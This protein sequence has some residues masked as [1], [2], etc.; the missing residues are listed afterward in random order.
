MSDANSPQKIFLH[1]AVPLG[2]YILVFGGRF[3]NFRKHISVSHHIIWMYN[4][5]TEQW[6]KYIIPEKELCPPDTAGSSAVAIT[7][8]VFLFGGYN[9]SQET[10]SNEL[11]ELS[12]SSKGS[13]TW[14]KVTTENIKVPSP[15]NDHSGWTYSGKLWIFGGFGPSLDRY[16]NDN[17]EFLH[18]LRG[19]CNNQLLSFNPSSKQWTNP[20]CSGFI[21]TP[22]DS[23]AS[24]NIGD[25]VWLYSGQNNSV[26][27]NELYEL[28]MSSLMWTHV[29]TGKTNPQTRT[30]CSLNAITHDQLLLYGGSGSYKTILN[31]TWILDLSSKTWKQYKPG[32]YRRLYHTGSKGINSNSII[33]GGVISSMDSCDDYPTT[34]CIMLEP[35]SLQQLAMQTI[36]KRRS[37]LPWECLPKK[38]I[39]LLGMSSHEENTGEI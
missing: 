3:G 19:S 13:F 36:Y 39:T 28:N 21:P 18:S 14:S 38:L 26:V 7:E 25:K 8:D 31:D 23:H 33:I 10:F 35:R 29:Q 9:I 2:E 32:N 22:R 16:L 11:W 17:G 15:R 27:F 37:L 24:T 5:Y 4:L 20:K 30:S 6:R 34:F 12:K 1:V